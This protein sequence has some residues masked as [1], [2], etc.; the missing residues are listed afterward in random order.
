MKP[1]FLDDS[2]ASGGASGGS[3]T[4][5]PAPNRPQESGGGA[6][7]GKGALD[8]EKFPNRPQKTGEDPSR[9]PKSVPDGGRMPFKGP[10]SPTKTPWKGF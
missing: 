3:S 10:S 7:T 2:G 6:E 5:D 9:N 4:P 8:E 1:S